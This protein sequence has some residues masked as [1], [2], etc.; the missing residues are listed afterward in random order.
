M[1]KYIELI[2]NKFKGTKSSNFKLDDLDDEIDLNVKSQSPKFNIT[3]F[4]SS[5]KV[6][7]IMVGSFIGVFFVFSAAGSYLYYMKQNS[8]NDSLKETIAQD[9]PVKIKKREVPSAKKE[10]VE[11]NT[12]VV[13]TQKEAQNTN[14]FA[15][16]KKENE[17]NVQKPVINTPNEQKPVTN[18]QPEQKVFQPQIKEE[19]TQIANAQQPNKKIDPNMLLKEISSKKDQEITEKTLF[20]EVKKDEDLLNKEYLPI[21]TKEPNEK[22]DVYSLTAEELMKL[23]EMDELLNKK[24]AYME[25]VTKYLD[26]K[27]KYLQA[28]KTFD[29]FSDDM[30]N[31]KKKNSEEE[32]K[33]ELEGKIKHLETLLN[34]K[35]Q[36]LNQNIDKISNKNTV[37][38]TEKGEPVLIVDKKEE[39]KKQNNTSIQTFFKGGQIFSMNGEFIVVLNSNGNDIV[40]KKGEIILNEFLISDVTDAVVTLE[41][42]NQLYFH[43]VKSNIGADTFSKVIVKMPMMI[44]NSS[45]EGTFNKTLDKKS[46][47]ANT[48]QYQTQEEKKKEEAKQFFNIKK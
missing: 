7:K 6:N 17:N 27:Q 24:Q 21:L 20:N 22:K 2:V 8:Q 26:K 12:P 48:K 1:N 42:D 10:N 23:N 15:E 4:A 37:T 28:L 38:P 45:E 46:T 39:M 16:L 29:D 43:N 25:K 32:M 41:K 40:Y 47:A 13:N 14:L 34:T 36:D 30:K 44:D 5:F 19:N 31:E 9:E 18:V 3:D 33:K 35:V 11:Q